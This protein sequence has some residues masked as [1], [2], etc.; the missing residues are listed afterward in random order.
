MSDF[1]LFGIGLGIVSIIVMCVLFWKM[2]CDMQ[3]EHQRRIEEMETEH[4]E[5]AKHV[6]GWLAPFAEDWSDPSEDFYDDM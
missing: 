1:Q 5:F 2:W 6:S 4:R 3:K